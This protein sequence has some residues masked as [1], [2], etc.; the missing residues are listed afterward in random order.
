MGQLKSHADVSPR[1]SVH[2]PEGSTLTE[3][4]EEIDNVE[5][6]LHILLA[7]EGGSIVIIPPAQDDNGWRVECLP[8]QEST[9]EAC[10]A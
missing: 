8:L 1:F 7:V 9:S 5:V 3:Q 4:G 2:Y 6:A 10:H